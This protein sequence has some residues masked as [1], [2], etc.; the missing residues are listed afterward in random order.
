ML[1]KQ[2]VFVIGAG[3]GFDVDMPLGSKLASEIAEDT[4]FRFEA[5]QLIGGNERVWTASRNMANAA[6]I[7]NNAT[8]AAGRM[9]TTG[10]AYAQSIDNY[11]HTHSDKEAVK[12]VAKNAIVHRIVEAERNSSLCIDQ[13]HVEFGRFKDEDKVRGSWLQAFFST[14]QDGVIEASNI[15][16]IFDNLSIINFNYDRCIEHFLFQAMQRLY[17]A[18]G[19][20]YLAGL[21]NRRQDSA[22]CFRHRQAASRR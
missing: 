9:I 20:K 12:I 2:T 19:T 5:K 15:E 22:R 4:Y 14:L 3:A 10:I 18:K 8:L 7:D 11:V 13:A 21:I 16:N 6:G 17:P 1:N